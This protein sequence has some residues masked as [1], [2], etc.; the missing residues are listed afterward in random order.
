MYQLLSCLG[1]AE[2]S[3]SHCHHHYCCKRGHKLCMEFSDKQDTTFG[4]IH[5]RIIKIIIWILQ[6]FHFLQVTTVVEPRRNQTQ[7]ERRMEVSVLLAI[8]VRT[9]LITLYLAQ[10]ER[11]SILLGW[12][13]KMT[14]YHVLLVSLLN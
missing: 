2:V 11:F 1:L 14:V 4:R 9:A 6:H 12:R 8:T 3:P 5:H 7:Q 13:L 10:L